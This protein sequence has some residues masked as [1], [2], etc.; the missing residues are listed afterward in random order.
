MTLTT[1]SSGVVARLSFLLAQG[2]SHFEIAI[3]PSISSSVDDI[4]CKPQVLS[5]DESLSLVEGRYLGLDARSLP[6]MAREIRREYKWQKKLCWN[7]DNE[8]TDISLSLLKTISCLLLVNPDHAT[9]WADRR[10]CLLQIS[11][12][13]TDDK[14]TVWKNE[15]DFVNLLMT[16]HSKA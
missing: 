4:D 1:E 6:A 14:S 9:A 13:S 2:P 3:L 8:D 11:N 16:Q 15:L 7:G 5:L 10:R 12:M